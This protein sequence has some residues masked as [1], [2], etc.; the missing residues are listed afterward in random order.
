MM[1][2]AKHLRAGCEGLCLTS[3]ELS[4]EGESLESGRRQHL[5]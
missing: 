5:G 3:G 1:E 4:S 2:K